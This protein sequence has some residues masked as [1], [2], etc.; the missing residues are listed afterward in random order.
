MDLLPCPARRRYQLG[1]A[2]G[3]R[4]AASGLGPETH[5]F[6]TK[7]TFVTLFPPENGVCTYTLRVR[8]RLVPSYYPCQVKNAVDFRKTIRW[9][10]PQGPIVAMQACENRDFPAPV[11]E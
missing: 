3:S 9:L 11:L 6:A 8:T 10:G 4:T 7:T 1:S 2:R 5:H